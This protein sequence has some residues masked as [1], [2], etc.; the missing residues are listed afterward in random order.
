MNRERRNN[1]R[2]VIN[3]CRSLLEEEI[4]RRVGY[5]GIRDNGE[6]IDT[7][8]LTHLD[9]E[10]LDI[11]QRLDKAV[12]KEKIG[13]INQED[14]TKRYLSHVAFTYLNRFSALRAMEVRGLI[15]ETIIRRNEYHGRSLREMDLAENNPDVSPESIL[16]TSLL[17][18][19]KEV[20]QEINVLFDTDDSYSIVFPDTRACL[21]VIKLL[22][23]VTLE[24]WKEDDI[25][26]WIYQYYNEEKRNEFRK[27]KRKPKPDDIPIISQFYT[28]DWI[29]KTLVDNTLGRL[30]L[31]INPKSKLSEI[32]KYYVSPENELQIENKPVRELKVL[33]P[34][35]GSG[36]FLVYA[37]E[38]LA[39][40]Y[41]ESEPETPKTEIA[42]LI[43]K[44]NLYGIDIDLRAC[45]L[46]ALSLFLKAK[47]YNARIKIKNM[48]VVCADI[49][50]A[51]GQKRADFLK[52]FDGDPALKEI[53]ERLFKDL[54]NTF[55]I[56]SLL[57]IRK[58]FEI[59]FKSRTS[60]KDYKQDKSELAH[61]SRFVVN[62][63]EG[64]SSISLEIPKQHTI[65][66]MTKQLLVLEEEA[67]ET[68][69]IGRLLF[70]TEAEKS[71]GLL[72][73]LTKKYDVI[74][75][76]PP[77]GT[78]TAESRGYIMEHY[79][80]TY[81]D[82]YAAFI[83]Q[84]I[85][86]AESKALIGVL[87]GRALLV[88]KTMQKL[89]EEI[90][91]KEGLP[92]IVLDLGFK[93]L[94]EAHARFAGMTIIKC[95]NNEK[96]K[97]HHKIRF[98][99]LARFE[100]DDKRIALERSLRSISSG[101]VYSVA[102]SDLAEV[103]G[104]PYA[105]WAPP[106]LRKIFGKFP[107]LDKDVAKSTFKQK[108]ADVKAGLQTS[109]DRRFIRY[110][111]EVPVYEIGIKREETFN[112]KKWVPFSN[113]SYLSYFYEDISLVVNWDK[114]GQEIRNFEKAYPRS[115]SFYFNQGLSWSANL[116]RTQVPKIWKSKRLPFRIMPQGSIFGLD[117]QAV[118]ISSDY[119]WPVLAICCSKLIFAISRMT[120]SEN[121]QGTSA[122]ASLPMALGKD[123]LDRNSKLY[124]LS[125][126]AHDILREWETGDETSTVFIKPWLIH[127]FS[128]KERP[129]TSH[130]FEKLFEWSHVQT[131]NELRLLK[132]STKMT[133]MELVEIYLKRKRTIESRIV[134]IQD[135]IDQEVYKLYGICEYDKMAIEKELE[136]LAGDG[137]E[138]EEPD[139]QEEI[140]QT[141][142]N[143]MVGENIAKE[144]VERLIFYY[145]NRAIKNDEDGI[146]PCDPIFKDNLLSKVRELILANFGPADAER[147]ETE[148]NQIVNKSLADWIDQRCFSFHVDLY[149]RRPIFWQ[150]SS[151]RFGR[152]KQAVGA[153]SCFVDY[154][155]LTRD[156]IPKIQGLYLKRVM[157]YTVREKDRLLKELES[158]KASHDQ[159][160]IFSVTRRYEQIVNRI[161]EL[162]EFDIA[163]RKLHNPQEHKTVIKNDSSWFDRAVAEVRDNGWRPVIHY[164]VRVNIEPMKQLKILHSS[165][166]RIK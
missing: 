133:L 31:S 12:E 22:L 14:A 21:E 27:A 33:D 61:Q 132:P 69:D 142:K 129:V 106:I 98:F 116:Q 115:A 162:Q 38:L 166:D 53:F 161:D 117:A 29:V 51:D 152:N 59:L 83:E 154:H 37:F 25:I 89:R 71:V 74:V 164:G 138:I 60:R 128:N 103:P 35:C 11:R 28:P 112:G 40:M 104:T 143:G 18:A 91:Q 82:S 67:L 50:V 48:N 52:R 64:E 66:D 84:A 120:T 105:Y 62:S 86:L 107:S 47:T 73:L 114:D 23:Q 68:K 95:A 2:S 32:C 85:N 144:Q 96:T 150:L 58:P 46:T 79:P 45:Q 34:A 101:L 125:K 1:L 57:Q 135:Q 15:K 165:A 131:S 160:R 80:R 122:T 136:I 127:Q 88:T 93:T 97:K 109:D 9:K 4:T 110:W 24:D 6:T 108:I 75:M 92:E 141:D 78:L 146:V 99:S 147:I 100:W 94:E 137:S 139:E 26:G 30:W 5:Y 72:D 111:W 43:L 56:G 102:L 156:T 3:Q 7:S 39:K 13:G 145:V 124:L 121:K 42:S 90:L 19:F 113:E 140:E 159:Q 77:H 17:D 55:A 157:E 76:N 148:M 41:E 118:I 149:R 54:S 119:I 81:Y 65:D 155:K 151:N 130:P 8:K 20:G 163:L 10:D 123:N 153:F 36:H 70:A 126:E 87:S 44:N 16:K 158:T 134:E 63:H 49:R